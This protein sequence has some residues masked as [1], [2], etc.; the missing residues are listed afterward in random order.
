MN[1]AHYKQCKIDI[2]S[3]IEIE[4]AIASIKVQHQAINTHNNKQ[5]NEKKEHRKQSSIQACSCNSKPNRQH[6]Q[7]QNTSNIMKTQK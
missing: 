7:K 5:I 1:E 3:T 6:D 2:K 4:A